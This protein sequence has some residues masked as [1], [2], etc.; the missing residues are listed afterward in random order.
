[1]HNASRI[2]QFSWVL[3]PALLFIAFHLATPEP[4]P[5]AA[6]SRT[7]Q[8]HALRDPDGRESIETV[9]DPARSSAF[10]H[11]PLGFSAGFTRSVHWLRVEISPLQAGQDTRS[12][13]DWL[14][15]HPPYLDDLRLYRPLPEQ[16]GAFEEIRQGDLL[17]FQAREYPYRSFIFGIPFID[18]EPQT[19]YLRLQTSSSSTAILRQWRPEAFK[20]AQ[21]REYGLQGLYYGV[22]LTILLLALWHGLWRSEPLLRA[23][24][25]YLSASLALTLAV[26]GLLAE[27]LLPA[28]PLLNQPL[29]ALFTLLTIAAGAHFYALALDI[30]RRPAWLHWLY[31]GLMWA[32]LCA[33]PSP[34]IDRYTE[35]AGPLLGWLTLMIA[36]GLL[37]SLLLW[38]RG[39]ASSSML[40]IAH[41]G[42]L[43]GGLS[44]A[45]TLLGVL[46]GQFWMIHGFQIGS[47]LTMLA[48]ALV[49]L[50]RMQLSILQRQAAEQRALLAEREREAERQARREQSRFVATF[51]HETRTPLT[52]IDGAAQSLA[53]LLKEPP[54]EVS[55]RLERIR[56][57]VRRL[58]G[59][60]EQFLCQ[61]RIDDEHLQVHPQRIELKVCIDSLI[62]QQESPERIRAS[63]D[64]ELRLQ[65]D[66][67]LLSVALGNLIDNACKYSPA[68]SPVEIDATRHAGGVQIRVRDHGAGIPAAEQTRIF[69]RYVRGTRGESVPGG[70]G[71]GLYLSRR[72]AELHGGRLSLATHYQSGCE[73][74][75]QLPDTASL[76]T[77]S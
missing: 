58:H 51:S 69:D 76:E 34:F 25:L 18:G 29:P 44:T 33:L 10:K 19:L 71:L 7:L 73:F 64:P 45:L 40:C 70:A 38:R 27:L 57:G 55:R 74:L 23:Y 42:T 11:Y 37:R 47:L 20:A 9:S 35:V 17:P 36:T 6:S 3:I 63:I 48:L 26:N 21:P 62:A 56:R 22:L 77:D 13:L 72:I 14:E 24:V 5:A 46:P 15:V 30:G 54:E 8:I 61:D 53:H 59:L 65:A 67:L 4:P 52:M 31:R 43:L 75:L 68:H 50:E 28:S 16:P 2:R 60:T 12:T 1:M 66:P 41:I 32:A 49:L 39:I